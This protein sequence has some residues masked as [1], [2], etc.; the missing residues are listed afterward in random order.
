MIYRDAQHCIA[1]AMSIEANDCTAKAGWQMKYR[2]G[3]PELPAAGCGLTP[4]ERLAQDSMARSLLYRYLP[5]REWH[6][7]VARYSINDR[8]VA[9]SVRWLVPF[10]Q[11]PAHRLFVFKAVTAW[12]VPRRLPAEFYQIHTWDTDGTPERTLRRWRL[13]VSRQLDGLVGDAKASTEG[14]IKLFGLR[15]DECG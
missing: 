13:E 1:R 7:L 4:E 2:P 8:E 6:A 11:S 3:Y 10:M 15:L 14:I 9:E 12:A 5:E